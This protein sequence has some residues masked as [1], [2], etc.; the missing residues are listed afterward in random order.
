MREGRL[1]LDQVGVIAQ[2]AG[3]GSD[4]HYA[5]LAA[6]ATV[7]QL[8]TAVKLEPRP[9]PRPRPEPQRSISKSVE[10]DFAYWRIKLPHLEAAKFEARWRL[11]GMR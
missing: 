2:R 4:E 5:A 6:V 8:R 1:A 9:D 10:D 3:D 7:T 11:I